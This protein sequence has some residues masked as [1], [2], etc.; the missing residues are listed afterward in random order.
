M[1]RE[2]WKKKWD[3]KTEHESKKKT[4]KKNV[5]TKFC[6]S[7]FTLTISLVFVVFILIR[8]FMTN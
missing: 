3:K 5:C 6:Y 7:S 8:Y 2:K 4:E 1:K